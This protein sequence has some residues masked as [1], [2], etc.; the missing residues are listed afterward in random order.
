MTEL[1]KK[2]KKLYDDCPTV[3]PRWEQLGETTK[4]VWMGRV[5]EPKK[6]KK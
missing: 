3:K 5:P 6:G 1:E 4:G 2:A